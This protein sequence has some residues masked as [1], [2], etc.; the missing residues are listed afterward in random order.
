[1]FGSGWKWLDSTD[2]GHRVGRWLLAHLYNLLCGWSLG[3]VAG[4]ASGQEL[5]QW[6]ALGQEMRGFVHKDL[7]ARGREGYGSHEHVKVESGILFRSQFAI[8]K[9][10]LLS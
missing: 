10:G 1:M 5:C 3:G 8:I 7:I 2:S 6:E 4:E 9:L